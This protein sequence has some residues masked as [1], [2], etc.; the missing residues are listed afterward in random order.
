MPGKYF[1]Y[2]RHCHPNFT[3]GTSIPHLMNQWCPTGCHFPLTRLGPVRVWIHCLAAPIFEDWE[4]TSQQSLH[5]DAALVLELAVE[6]P[7]DGAHN[8][9]HDAKVALL[10][11]FLASWV[12]QILQ[13]CCHQLAHPDQ[14]GVLEGRYIPTGQSHSYCQAVIPAQ[15]ASNRTWS[16]WA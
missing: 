2:V 14:Q 5:E 10:Q 1:L 16:E 8:P 6:V 11:D 13:H 4:C 3:S 12:Q 9:Q 7:D 15:N